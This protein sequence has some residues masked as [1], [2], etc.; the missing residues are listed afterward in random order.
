MHDGLELPSYN[1]RPPFRSPRE[2]D[3]PGPETNI[4]DI[5]HAQERE[6]D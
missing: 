2:F 3:T 6:E 5:D 1:L 4:A